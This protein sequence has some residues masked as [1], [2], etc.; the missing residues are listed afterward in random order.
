MSLLQD[1][2]RA[3]AQIGEEKYN[4]IDV[5]IEEIC[6]TER[7]NLYKQEL[8]KI[9]HLEINEWEKEKKKL[10]QKYGIVYLD[11]IL[12]NEKGWK[13]FEEWYKNYSSK[14]IIIEL[15]PI[16]IDNW[17]RPVYIN[18]DGKIYKDI[19]LGQ[20][21]LRDS[22]CS[23]VNN[24]FYGEPFIPL[25]KDKNIEIKI[26]EKFIENKNKSRER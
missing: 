5:Y 23:A 7:R 12:Y 24:E 21:N 3:K 4:A 15:K 26:V 14:K 9:D 2:E 6:P 1:Y 25:R 22:L 19:S 10:E 17:D 20:G 11:D 8:K 13:K 16:G 18:K